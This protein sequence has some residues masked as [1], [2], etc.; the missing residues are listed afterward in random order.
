MFEDRLR[1][2]RIDT[3][4]T[5]FRYPTNGGVTK[6]INKNWGRYTFAHDFITII[7]IMQRLTRRV[8][9][10]IQMSVGQMSN[11]RRGQMKLHFSNF[12]GA[13]NFKL[14]TT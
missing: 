1:Q 3:L 9:V 10:K 4:I 12:F 11:R 2:T 13:E 7:I 14:L 8:S 5:I 6:F